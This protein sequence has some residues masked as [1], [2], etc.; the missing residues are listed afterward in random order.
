[1]GNFKASLQNQQRAHG[2]RIKLFGKYHERTGARNRQLE[3]TQRVL[4]GLK[5][6]HKLF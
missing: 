3:K 4:D 6:G 5:G 1:M 2:V